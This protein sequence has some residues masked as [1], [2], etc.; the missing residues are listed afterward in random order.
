MKQINYPIKSK[1]LLYTH[2]ECSTHVVL[3]DLINVTKISPNMTHCEYHATFG[4][5]AI[6]KMEDISWLFVD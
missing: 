3:S 2:D 6:K 1:M 4:Y 5:V